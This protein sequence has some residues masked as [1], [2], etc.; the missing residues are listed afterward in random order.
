M[1]N[2]ELRHNYTFVFSATVMIR[3]ALFPVL[4]RFRKKM[5]KL[6]NV[7]PQ[8]QQFQKKL[9]EAPSGEEAKKIQK[10][11]DQ[12]LASKGVSLF[13]GFHLMFAQGIVFMS[14][15]FGLRE[16][17]NLP[18]ESLK[19][20]G[21]GWFTD[22]TISDPIMLLPVL[23]S[24]S[25]FV[26]ISMGAE[27]VDPNSVPPLMKKFLYWMPFLSLPVMVQFPAVSFNKHLLLLVLLTVLL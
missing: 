12:F 24:A 16:M 1:P 25:L 3:L 7:T 21:M 8:I 2:S 13:G 23:T 19:I 27:G 17:A 18:V 5:V 20:G 9:I 6:N 11:M 10:E 22:L 15:F 14:M 26:N 4:I